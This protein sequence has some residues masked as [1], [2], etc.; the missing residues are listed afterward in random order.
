VKRQQPGRVR[1]VCRPSCRA[2]AASPL[3]QIVTDIQATGCGSISLAGR[4]KC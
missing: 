3:H 2:V 4:S 1:G